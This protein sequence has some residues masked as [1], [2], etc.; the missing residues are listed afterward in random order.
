MPI[1]QVSNSP[2]NFRNRAVR[3]FRVSLSA[4]RGG[5]TSGKGFRSGVEQPQSSNA[6]S[7]ATEIYDLQF[8]SYSAFYTRILLSSLLNILLWMEF[9]K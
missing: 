4:A 6:N 2:A 9:Y 7:A 1:P 5:S 8:I 3:A